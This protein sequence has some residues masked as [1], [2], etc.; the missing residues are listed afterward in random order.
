M[1]I[2][3]FTGATLKEATERMKAELGPDAIVINSRKAA[4]GGVMH[5]MAKEAFEITAAVEDAPLP[6]KHPVGKSTGFA[7]ELAGAHARTAGSAAEPPSTIDGLRQLAERFEQQHRAH[8]ETRPPSRRAE[9]AEMHT[10]KG[11]V[12]DIKTTLREIAEQMKYTRMPSLPPALR[13]AYASLVANDVPEDFASEIVQAV[14]GK[15]GATHAE[16]RTAVEKQL[17]AEISR[18]IRT[19]EP[20]AAGKKA[21]VVAL[22]GPTGVGKTTTIAKL[23]AISKLVDRE[24]VALISADTYR[25]G[26]IEQLKTFAAIADIPMEVVYKPADIKPAL[27][28]FRDAGT[29]YLDTVGRSQKMKKDLAELAKFVDAAGP[30]EVH[31]VLSASTGASTMQDIVKN[32]KALRPNRLL[33]SKLDEAAHLGPVLTVL[34]TAGVPASYVTTGQGVPDDILPANAGQLASMVYAGAYSHA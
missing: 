7:R 20:V 11:D 9:S 16:N 22:V 17:I 26:A 29:I 6:L 28:K 15:L 34:R 18:H 23:A 32:F 31:L 4:K 1:R 2:K 24:D 27:R 13:D 14:Y 12:D 5:F 19:A 33:F 10:L 21:R 25:I 8:E 30:D 3:K